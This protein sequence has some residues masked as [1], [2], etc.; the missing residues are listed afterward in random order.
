MNIYSLLFAAA[1]TTQA[2]T[3]AATV[4]GT[5]NPGEGF[6]E[7]SSGN[8]E[9]GWG[10]K[11][12]GE[13]YM[14]EGEFKGGEHHGVGIESMPEGI[15]YIGQ[16]VDGTPNGYGTMRFPEQAGLP[17]RGYIGQW[18]DDWPHGCGRDSD[19]E[20]TFV[21]GAFTETADCSEH[22]ASAERIIRD[23]LDRAGYDSDAFLSGDEGE[24]ELT[25]EQL[26][27]YMAGVREAIE[28]HKRK[29]EDDHVKEATQ[30][31]QD[32]QQQLDD[33][34]AREGS[35]GSNAGDDVSVEELMDRIDQ[36]REAIRMHEERGETEHVEGATQVLREMEAQLDELQRNGGG[37]NG[38]GYGDDDISIDELMDRIEQVRGAIQMHE[39]RGETEHVEGATQVLREMEAQ[40]DAMQ[41][42]GGGG[43]GGYGDDDITAD[44]LL[45]RID[46]VR[47]AIQ[48]HE[49]RG[50]TEHVEGAT[51]VLRELEAQL[52]DMQREGG[53]GDYGDDDITVDE[54]LDRIEQVREA[55]KMHEERGETEHVE[56][57]T[58]VLR[59]MEAQLDDLQ[60]SGGGAGGGYGDDDITVDELLDRI[61][62]VRGAIQMHEERGETEHVEGATQV[63]RELEAQLDDMQREGGGGDY[64][65]DD[66]TVDELLDR[67][68]Q[69]R[70]A[71][72]MHEER[73]ETEHVEGATQ[74]LREMEAQLDHMQRQPA[75]TST[76]SEADELL[77][78]IAQVKE[79][80]SY[81][82]GRGETEHVQG[83]TQVLRELE[84]ELAEL[85][86]EDDLV[87]VD[88]MSADEIRDRVD[89]LKVAVREHEE[90]GE[91]DHAE[92][93]GKIL[94][95]FQRALSRVEGVVDSSY[96]A[97]GSTPTKRSLSA[98]SSGSRP[99]SN[100]RAPDNSLESMSRAELKSVI[101]QTTG[102][103]ERHVLAGETEHVQ[104]AG[105]ALL[106][107][108]NQYSHTSGLYV[109][110]EAGGK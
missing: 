33:L 92:E 28:E 71:I 27:E 89:L 108:R 86:E 18:K 84:E 14:Y 93:A 90:K 31:L 59:E 64:G 48:M 68:E 11:D 97:D 12:Y 15:Q 26:E 16:F 19:N 60:R 62:Q 58:Q 8:C 61:E 106:A 40:L 52:D 73:G 47:G 99:S 1:V 51:Q 43:G 41:R 6:G 55:I 107:L 110:T 25:V 85:Q 29:G 96:S 109:E 2:S 24:P 42:T 20:G 3:Q 102:A 82:E 7:C 53:G 23:V 87:D 103:Y 101:E 45:E 37:G 38:G 88:G 9:D 36:I 56:G 17:Q 10:V 50:E 91:H 66:I 30:V 74:V 83:A 67:I 54:L 5:G 80:I 72:K 4:D 63:L 94:R 34:L 13:D 35:R 49:E 44:E 21:E 69:V 76:E 57:A 95:A 100:G 98:P 39:E 65:D 79:A 75:A 104:G 78:R 32:M 22:I 46:Q 81:H 105:T 77:D 70:E